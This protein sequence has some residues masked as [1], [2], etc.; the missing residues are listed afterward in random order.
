MTFLH[1]TSC[2]MDYC[3]W[4]TVTLMCEDRWALSDSR[5]GEP[6][7]PIPLRSTGGTPA[8]AVARSSGTARF[9]GASITEKATEIIQRSEPA[10]AYFPMSRVNVE[11][12]PCWGRLRGLPEECTGLPDP[13]CPH[14]GASF[15]EGFPKSGGQ[16][17]TQ[18]EALFL[19]LDLNIDGELSAMEPP[20]QP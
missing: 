5:L 15:K 7:L 9:S 12:L 17:I 19:Q 8:Q 3:Q 18:P 4:N 14:R 1:I 2:P 11:T 6:G 13:G 16:N 10:A 20:C